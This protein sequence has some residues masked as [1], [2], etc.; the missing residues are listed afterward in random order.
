MAGDERTH[1]TDPIRPDRADDPTRARIKDAAMRLFSELG[2]DAAS[3]RAIVREAGARNGASLHYYFGSKEGLIRELV[4]D[5]ARRSDAARIARLDALEARGGP[6]GPADIVGM[7][8]AVE[9]APAGPGPFEGLPV[10]FGHMRF[11]EALQG[12]HRALFL[13]AVGDRWTAGFDRCMAA[14]RG[15]LGHLAPAEAGRRLAF[16]VVFLNAGLAAREAAFV[17]DPSGG[18]LW[19]RPGA[20]DSFVT[21]LCGGLMAPAPDRDPDQNM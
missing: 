21:S 18:R 3:V 8:V 12:A 16:L 20:L 19:G 1:E 2:V 4:A 11:V 10:G 13:D 17:A 5:A 14:L 7:M 15:M 9:T 6:A